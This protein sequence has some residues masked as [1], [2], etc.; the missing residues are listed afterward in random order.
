MATGEH[1]GAVPDF[2]RMDHAVSADPAN[3]KE[4]GS[5]HGWPTKDIKPVTLTDD[6]G[7]TVR[8]RTPVMDLEG[9]ITPTDLHYTVQHFAVPPVVHANDWKLEIFGEVKT[10][11][12]LNFEQVRHF[13]GR[14]VRTVME[15]SGSDATYF[16]YFRGEGP[17]PSRTQEGMILSASEWTGVPL[18]AVL[19][20]AGLTAKSL[21]VRA[22]GND[23]G[24]PATATEGT[25]PFYYDKGLPMEKAL[26]PDTILAWAQNGQ[27]LEHLHG[28]P[29]RLLVPGWSGNWSVKWLNKLEIMKQEP[30]CWYHY[31]F[32]YYGTS[33][34]DPNKE[35]ITTIGVKSIITH[36]N[37][38]TETMSPGIHMIRG[39]AWSGAG[40]IAQVEVSVDGGETW[41]SAHIEP[42]RERFMW[43]R[44]SYHWNVR[45]KGRYTLM[46]RATDEVGRVQSREPLYNNMRKNFSAIVGYTVTVA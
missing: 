38:D 21:Y 7:R 8:I 2:L 17:R 23:L 30:T 1:E 19:Y 39:Y 15:C 4:T 45:H 24:V 44:W 42:P 14:S 43:A 37:D 32:Y 18:A 9:P 40:A 12:T 11:L 29:V 20:E 22:E 31:E 27:L 35:L 25:K 16:E 41:H 28:A 26:H 33:A 13:P 3:A 46:S 6:E 5:W 36:P 10:P 34:T